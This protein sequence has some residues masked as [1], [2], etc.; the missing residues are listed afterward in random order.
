MQRTGSARGEPPCLLLLPFEVRLCV[1]SKME[2]NALPF[3]DWDAVSLSER[4]SALLRRLEEKEA[5]V[6]SLRATL[7]ELVSAAPQRPPADT[8]E[9][10][11]FHLEQE[12]LA[13]RQKCEG[14]TV[15]NARLHRM[16]RVLNER[17]GELEAAAAAR[18]DA[19][20]L[21]LQDA[22]GLGSPARDE[23]HA[24]SPS[25]ASSGAGDRRLLVARVLIS[26]LLLQLAEAGVGIDHE[27]LLEPLAASSSNGGGA[28]GSST[29]SGQ[30]S[31]P[32][33]ALAREL[34]ASF[35][36][37]GAGQQ[38]QGS[39]E[40][41]TGIAHAGAASE[42]TGAGLR[43]P[44]ASPTRARRPPSLDGPRGDG[45]SFALGSPVSPVG[46]R[47]RRATSDGGGAG[48]GEGSADNGEAFD[49]SS[50]RL[51]APLAAL[52]NVLVGDVNDGA[53]LPASSPL[54]PPS[55]GGGVM[56]LDF[57]SPPPSSTQGATSPA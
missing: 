31:A 29:G 37:L 34:I 10:A 22:G 4:I 11:I 47:S 51:I 25:A 2:F 19:E 38:Q 46:V 56:P 57:A 17:V 3:E 55:P 44:I 48:G 7:N 43:T 23:A 1:A 15:Q 33:P 53:T 52:W 14:L 16:T 20:A 24:S 54:P 42:E 32:H 21:L 49:G 50:S 27:H 36:Y 9:A 6:E 26:R 5:L 13:L 41:G 40:G 8:P 39:E 30:A 18:S 35:G 12:N 45:E 28:E